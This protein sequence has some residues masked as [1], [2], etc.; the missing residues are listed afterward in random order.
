MAITATA[1]R[2]TVRLRV[3]TAPGNVGKSM[4]VTATA[5]GHAEIVRGWS[6]VPAPSTAVVIDHEAPLERDV[7]YAVLIDGAETDAVTVRLASDLPL[8]TDPIRGRH[9]PV[10]IQ[11]WPTQSYER[12]GQELTIDGSPD[13]VIIEGVEMRPRSTIT[14][15]HP[16]TGIGA[17]DLAELLAD[18]SVL[19]IRPTTPDLP[20]AWASTRARNRGRFSTATGSAVVDVLELQ[21]IA[22]PDPDTTAIGATL[23]DLHDAVPTT[24]GAIHLRWPGT[25]ADIALE[26]F[27]A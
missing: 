21:H 4:T 3:T 22:Q 13:P 8:L 14:L 23:G 7:R 6:S 15:I 9:V 19:R 10:I 17:E 11:S 2:G 18:R 12:T 16:P 20:D 24:L 1:A 27:T 25:L 26:D 5:T